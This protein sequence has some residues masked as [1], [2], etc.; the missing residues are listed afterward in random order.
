MSNHP[1]LNQAEYPFKQH[2]FEVDGMEMN[3]IDEGKGSPIVMVHGTPSWSFL[4]RNLVKELM[5]NHRCIAPDNLGFGLSEKRENE[6][7]R[8]ETQARR[9]EEFI[10]SLN[11]TDITLVVH[12]FGGP[13]GLNYAIKHP[14]KVSR[15]V[16]SNTW[17]WSLADNSQVK[18][19]SGFFAKPLGKWLY[20]K[21][22]FSAGFL[23]KQGFNR[24]SRLTK[25][26]HS[27]YKNPFS[28]AVERYSTWVY[29]KELLASADWYNELWEQREK[30]SHI[31]TLLLWGMKDKFFGPEVLTKWEGVFEENRA[32]KLRKSGHF[33]QEEN[34]EEYNDA[35]QG[36]LRTYDKTL[37]S[38]S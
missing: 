11:L 15:L 9:L 7:Y 30:I 23:F 21:T 2:T 10:E 25:F 19:A 26:V 24:K 22:N 1:W 32:F 18:R 13:I 27:H 33:I 8:P 17:M 31:P 6:D 4:Y 34:N 38:I 36:F 3:Y 16:I 28:N 14:E 35:I 29:A 5:A 37:A 20:T 12:D